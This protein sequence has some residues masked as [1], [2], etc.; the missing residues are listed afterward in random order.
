MRLNHVPASTGIR[1]IGCGI[2]S[3]ARQPLAMVGLFL[4]FM[5]LVS[6]LSAV[7]LLGQVVALTLVPA[8]TWGLVQAS[9]LAAQGQFPMPTVLASGLTGTAERRK[10]LLVLGGFYVVGML[11]VLGLSALVDGGAFAAAYT[12]AG[13]GL[14]VDL[15]QREEVQTA[16]WVALLAYAPFSAVFWHAPML[17][18]EHGVPP[19]KSLFFSWMACWQ[20]KGA[21]AAYLMGWLALFLTAAMT[22]T[23]LAS[24]MGGGNLGGAII[25]PVALVLAAMFFSSIRCSFDDS[26]LTPEPTAPESGH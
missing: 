5:T 19:G 13:E 21:M 16:A 8:A 9:R 20:N 4:L 18:A 24:L 12:G 22:T 23:L 14:S 2:R 25:L 15:L 1:W 10:N 11:V 7:P 3:F 26:F 17:V 6:L